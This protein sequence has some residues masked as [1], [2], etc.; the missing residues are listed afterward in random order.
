[1]PRKRLKIL[2]KILQQLEEKVR[3]NVLASIDK[4]ITKKNFKTSSVIP[5]KNLEIRLLF[6]KK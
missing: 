3:R 1:M 5:I 4:L 6:F 2:D